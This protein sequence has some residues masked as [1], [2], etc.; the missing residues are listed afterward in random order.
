MIVVIGAS[1]FLGSHLLCHLAQSNNKVRALYRNP[2]SIAATEHYLQY[3]NLTD[4]LF[5]NNIEWFKAD[6]LDV[7]SMNDALRGAS[8]VYNCS[9]FV[10]FDKRDKNQMIAVNTTG[11]ANIVNACLH[12][13]CK[14]L[15]HVSSIAALGETNNGEP[16]TEE[17]QWIRSASESWY[18]ITKFY[19]ETEAWRGIAEGLATVIVNS[20]VIL[21][22]ETG[23]KEVP[24]YLKRLIRVNH[25]TQRVQPVMLMFEMYVEL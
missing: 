2:Q 6:V 16:V 25:F 15:V 19:G 21:G 13:S 18:S 9:G 3:Y 22:R 20:S 14:K 11:T 8:Y 10:S 4:N 1:G 7:D 24:D 17:T 5:K 23:I 12:N